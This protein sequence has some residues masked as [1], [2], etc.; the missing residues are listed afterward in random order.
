LKLFTDR[1]RAVNP[2][3]RADAANTATIH[4]LCRR[5][6]GIALAIELAAARIRS[7]S[8]D[9]LS[10]H[11][12]LLALGGGPR[13]RQ[14]RQQTM[15]AL[16]A[17]SYNLL[18]PDEQRL[19]RGAAVFSGGFTIEAATAVFGDDAHD[20]WSVLDLLTSLV[21]KSLVVVDVGAADQRYRLLESIRA[22][23]RERLDESGETAQSLRRHAEIFST[24]ADRAYV[25]FD[26]APS[27]DWLSKV[28]RELD[29]FRGALAWT[30]NDDNAV[31]L[32]AGMA[33]D[34]SPLFMRLSLLREGI[35]WCERA[36]SLET[37]TSPGKRARLYYGLSMLQH[38]QGVNDSALVSATRAV[39]LYREVHDERGLV[40]ALSQAA[41]QL[42]TRDLYEEAQV[43]AQEAL[44]HA[45]ELGDARLLAGTL[46]RCA[47]VYRPDEIEAARAQFA[48]S[49]ALFRSLGRNDETARA[50]QWWAD[51]ESVAGELSA[52]A[53]IAREALEIASEDIKLY[54]LN[55]LASCY[56]ALGDRERAG[57]AGRQAFGLAVKA[58]HPVATAC[59]ILYLAAI[60]GD[61]DATRAARLFGYAE[62]RLRGL[63]WKLVGP[64][65]LIEAALAANLQ[66]RLTTDEWRSLRADGAAWSEEAAL[67][68][69]VRV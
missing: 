34:V 55:G 11:V 45:R 42:A 2:E 20:E 28:E 31:D 30:L 48:E 35:G 67:D 65:C 54:V 18:A 27:P 52:S 61:G 56:L 26:T 64:D 68:Q 24:S 5:L 58:G 14:P 7:V 33:A 66:A 62:A 57:P 43:E 17:W 15:R 23:A 4:D 53:A 13:D 16:I 63:G 21:D 39:A 12:R 10:R 32:G 60:E 46:Q 1:A 19:F 3:F 41:H 40:R 25:E 49:V 6:D 8:L 69:A 47:F 37:R 44:A 51:A 59:A 50:L 22:Y 36:L 9:D 38:N 29:N